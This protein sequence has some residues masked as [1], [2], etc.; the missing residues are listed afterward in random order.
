MQILSNTNGGL[1]SVHTITLA[2]SS[3]FRELGPDVETSWAAGVHNNFMMANVEPWLQVLAAFA[4]ICPGL[5]RLQAVG[6]FREKWLDTLG[7]EMAARGARLVRGKPSQTTP[8]YEVC[9]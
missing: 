2:L 9:E 5:E 7:E 8:G 6:V 4:E 3:L 1:R